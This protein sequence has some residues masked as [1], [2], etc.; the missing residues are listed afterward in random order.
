[1]KILSLHADYIKFQPTKKALKD[2]EEVPFEETHVSE[3]LAVL[4]SVEK[5]DESNPTEISHKL[6]ENIEDISN[7]VKTKTIVLYPYAHLSSNLASPNIA[8]QILK[9]TE[10]HLKDKEYKVTRAP[11][12]YYKK[13][14]ISC[15]GHPL[16]E[17]S[18]EIKIE[19]GLKRDYKD[20]PFV[21]NPKDL[22]EEEKIKLSSALVIGSAVK[23]LYPNSELGSFGFYNEQAYI[24][25]ANLKL[26]KDE[27]PKI[28][29]KSS[30][31][32]K[33]NLLFKESSDS[34]SG[35]QKEILE[36][37]GKHGKIY[38]IKNIKVA[39]LFKQPFINSTKKITSLKILNIASAYWKN[40]E[41][42][43]QLTRINCIGF[44]SE[45]KLEEYLKLQQDLEDRSHI[46]LGKE[47]GLF[48][49]SK[50]VGPGLPLLAPKGMILRHEIINYLW[51]LH[52]DKGYQMVW[53]PHIAKDLL[54][55]QSGHWDKFG[56]ELFIVE[57]KQ[58]KFV[59]K[60]MNCPHH[61]QIFQNFSY[62]YKDMPIRYF[63]PATVYRDEKSGQLH[64]LSR[65]RAITQDDGHLFCRINQIKPEVKSIVKIILKFYKTLGMDK[66]Y[67]VSLSIRGD[68]KSK[69]LGDDSVW[70]KA[71]ESLE[72]VA[73]ENKLPFKKIKG[74]AAFYGPK[75]DFIFKDVLGREWQLATIQ[76]DFNLPERFDL[77]F[78]NEKDKKERPVMIHRAIS[79]S[80][81]RFLS[82]LIE[83]F[84]GNFPLW[85]APVQVKIL[86]ITDRSVKFAKEVYELLLQNNIRAELDDRPETMNKKSLE[87]RIQKIP[88]IITIGDDEVKNQK[89]AVKKH[90]GKLQTNI[91][92]HELI[93]ELKNE[94][95]SKALT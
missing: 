34:V 62:S 32:L 67:W 17:L 89:L 92:P 80:L 36:D 68:D 33:E 76:L 84:A 16:S 59:V 66:N 39:S 55:K 52:K 91:S 21:Y 82:V 71:E 31:L 77:Y 25:I 61:I 37:I 1:M 60:P 19:S 5:P 14:D 26:T 29:K 7:Q 12:G 46:K 69:Y 45:K 64:G 42:N 18:R 38:E 9:D 57:G 20:K 47:L 30:A 4:I 6:V 8:L 2:V 93:E 81:E 22:T 88:V 86:T 63:E 15:K 54:Y 48:V 90:S 11:F 94:I 49:I 83:H 27:L 58:E 78:M 13:F 56:D 41:K 51:E 43:Q 3:C 75:L 23:E 35:L 50:L 44:D 40:N 65:V 74:E 73:T 53:T 79:G 24:D 95:S 72:E 85:L 10:K 70:N 87:A 28:E